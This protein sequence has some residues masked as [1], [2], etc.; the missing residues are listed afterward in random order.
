MKSVIQEGTSLVK[1]L[2]EGWEK[3]G[4][5][6]EFSVK[7]FQ[8]PEYGFLGL[9]SKKK[10][11]IGI[12]FEEKIEAQQKYERPKFEKRDIRDTRDDRSKDDKAKPQGRRMQTQDRKPR[13]Q[14]KNR[15]RPHREPYRENKEF[16]KK[17]DSQKQMN[18]NEPK[19]V[20]RDAA[21]NTNSD[22]KV[23]NAFVTRD[24]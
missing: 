1:A 19:K 12:F 5:P 7:I 4:R 20:E 2:E 13:Y 15:N 22:K 24:K 17:D 11:K 18:T 23:I 8:E 3:A 14:D 16:V 6:T 21:Q 10:A 9:S